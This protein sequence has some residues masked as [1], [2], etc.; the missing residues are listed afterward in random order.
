M[1]S[2]SYLLQKKIIISIQNVKK[3]PLLCFCNETFFLY[4]YLF[5]INRFNQIIK[6]RRYLLSVSLSISIIMQMIARFITTA[7]ELFDALKV[8]RVIRYIHK[9][10]IFWIF[11]LYPKKR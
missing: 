4:I 6:K 5:Y 10:Y 3:I 11:I 1:Y 8:N 9:K 2:I 7:T